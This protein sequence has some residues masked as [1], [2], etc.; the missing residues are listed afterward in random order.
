MPLACILWT[1]GLDVSKPSTSYI[2]TSSSAAAFGGLLSCHCH[3][4]L[5]PVCQQL[6]HGIGAATEA[7][8]DGRGGTSLAPAAENADDTHT[9]HSRA[10]GRSR[11]FTHPVSA[12]PSWKVDLTGRP[13]AAGPPRGARR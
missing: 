5:R 13:S 12:G 1:R 6:G 10:R 9:A 11:I 8:A 7:G 2:R 3:E 4:T